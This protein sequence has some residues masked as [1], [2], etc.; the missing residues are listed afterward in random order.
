MTCPFPDPQSPAMTQVEFSFEV[1]FVFCLKGPLL[2]C[3]GDQNRRDDVP[4]KSTTGRGESSAYYSAPSAGERPSSSS[5]YYDASV[6][7]YSPELAQ[8]CPLPIAIDLAFPSIDK[9]ISG[10]ADSDDQV[11]RLQ[12]EIDELE[13]DY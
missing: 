3:A 10:Y 8:Q 4:R 1:V 9:H 11:R 6:H 5:P 7:T 12:A 2:C 13:G